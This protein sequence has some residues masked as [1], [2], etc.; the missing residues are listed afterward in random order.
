MSAHL[1]KEASAMDAIKT[2][3]STITELVLRFLRRSRLRKRAA[4]SIVV[5]IF[6]VTGAAIP[7]SRAQTSGTT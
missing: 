6:L 3:S 7:F 1:A 5:T 2:S 4:A